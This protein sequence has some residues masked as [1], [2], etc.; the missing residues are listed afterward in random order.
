MGLIHVE[1]ELHAHRQMLRVLTEQREGNFELRNTVAEH[2]KNV[3]SVLKMLHHNSKK[4]E[5]MLSVI[6]DP[7]SIN[8]AFAR[9]TCFVCLFVVFLFV[10]T[11]S[12][13]RF[14]HKT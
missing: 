13:P 11:H 3:D 4:G 5:W 6:H 7:L 8:C 2:D 12:I 9:N 10:F 1:I 14:V